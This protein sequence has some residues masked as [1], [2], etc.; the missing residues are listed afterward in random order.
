MYRFERRQLLN[1]FNTNKMDMRWHMF[2]WLFI[3][4]EVG[5]GG[6]RWLSLQEVAL[7]NTNRYISFFNETNDFILDVC[8]MHAYFLC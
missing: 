8:G 7:D 4:T 3:S 1:Y 5:R 6:M 2:N